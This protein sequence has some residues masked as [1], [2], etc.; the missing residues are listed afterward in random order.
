MYDSPTRG[1]S[2]KDHY[3]EMMERS[4]GRVNARQRVIERKQ[5]AIEMAE[6]AKAVADKAKEKKE[7]EKLKK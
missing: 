2:Y 1:M 6:T 7:K 5:K 3:L 4:E